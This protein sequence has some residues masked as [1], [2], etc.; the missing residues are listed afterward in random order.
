M[1]ESEVNEV[2][3]REVLRAVQL[4]EE[5]Y[6]HTPMELSGGQQQR[7]AV[8]RASSTIP[9]S[10]CAMNLRETLIQK[11]GPVSWSHD[12][13]QQKRR[14]DHRSDARSQLWQNTRTG[15]S[16]SLTGALPNDL[17]GIAKRNV[18]IHMLRSS[19]AMLG[20]VIGVVAIASMGILGNSMVATVSESLSSV[21]D[22]VIVTPYS[23]GGGGM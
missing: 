18:R 5:L 19:L 14:H 11:R 3:A 22:S 1:L 10:S 23:G 6:T 13:T 8:A 12:G 2:R 20:I 15:R 21:G 17:L 7:V 16:G 9:T 4:E